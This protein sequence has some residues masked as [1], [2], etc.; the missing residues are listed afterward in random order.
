MQIELR[1]FANFREAVGQKTVQREYENGL[2][3]GDVL[4]Q[5]SEEFTEMDLFEDGELREYLTILRNGTDIAHLDGLET[6]LEDG[7]ELSVFPPVAGG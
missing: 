6:A 2:L 3:A 4:R 1:F 7:D 5:L